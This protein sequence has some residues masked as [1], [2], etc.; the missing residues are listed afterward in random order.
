MSSSF[1]TMQAALSWLG[2]RIG[3]EDNQGQDIIRF[4]KEAVDVLH[5]CDHA[6]GGYLNRATYRASLG[7][8]TSLEYEDDKE[9]A[10]WLSLKLI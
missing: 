10:K 7:I 8:L 5:N 6:Q 2:E 1:D 3:T 4:L 9:R